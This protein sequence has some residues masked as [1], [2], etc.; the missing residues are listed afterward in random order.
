MGLLYYYRSRVGANVFVS[1]RDEGVTLSKPA[2]AI[3]ICP[4]C[5]KNLHEWFASQDLRL[6]PRAVNERYGDATLTTLLI[7]G[8]EMAKSMH[9]AIALIVSVFVLTAVTIP[10]EVKHAPSLQSCEADLRLWASQLEGWPNPS[11][12]QIHAGTKSL[13]FD[14]LAGRMFSIS[15][16]EESYPILQRSKSGELSFPTTLVSYYKL[17]ETERYID[18]IVRHN[19]ASKFKEEDQAGMR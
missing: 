11:M 2:F 1:N 7:K 4:F 17:E 9:K 13:T 12:D 8:G 14:E 18:F 3:R 10:Q 5:G 6:L 15:K 16:C 19:L